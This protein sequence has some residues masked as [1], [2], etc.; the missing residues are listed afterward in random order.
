MGFSKDQNWV[1][2]SSEDGFIKIFDLR[3]QG[4][5]RQYKNE[6]AVNCIQLHPNEGDLVVG[7]Q[8]G[9]IKI[10]DLVADKCRQTIDASRDIGIRSLS[11]SINAYCLVAA[12]GAGQCHVYKLR[13]CEEL[14]LL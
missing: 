9:Q 11:I 4:F 7:D 6:S 3:A 14:E 13:N 2:G 8:N 5:K 1:Y 12:D 10:Y